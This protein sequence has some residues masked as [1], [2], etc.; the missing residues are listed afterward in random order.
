MDMTKSSTFDYVCRELVK[1]PSKLPVLIMSNFHDLHEQRKITEEQV[2]TFLDVVTQSTHYDVTSHEKNNELSTD[3]NTQNSLSNTTRLIPVQ[4]CESSMKT[5]LGLMY[6]YKFLNIPFLCLQRDVLHYQLKRNY[7]EMIS[8]LSELNPK[9]GNETPKQH[10]TDPDETKSTNDLPPICSS[11]SSPFVIEGSVKTKRA[12]T[13]TNPLNLSDMY[14]SKTS[15]IRMKKSENTNKSTEQ[16]EQ[17]PVVLAFSEEIDPADN[18]IYYLN[19]NNN[20]ESPTRSYTFAPSSNNDDSDIC[21][22]DG[23]NLYLTNKNSPHEIIMDELQSDLRLGQSNLS[24]PHHFNRSKLKVDS[25][26]E[27]SD[28]LL[29]QLRK[30]KSRQNN[31]EEEDDAFDSKSLTNDNG[32]SISNE[33]IIILPIDNDALEQFLEDS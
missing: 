18:E 21:G 27:N 33:N 20:L 26:I 30:P 28:F 22:V 32:L 13:R 31:T 23:D 16:L 12:T 1:I 29:G 5:G 9:V 6:V 24:Y 4:Y 14:D 3:I 11:S 15:H 8:I 25:T 17:I 7:N 10:Y 19:N 2:R